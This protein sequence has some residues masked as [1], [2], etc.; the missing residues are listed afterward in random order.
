MGAKKK[1]YGMFLVKNG[2][3][4]KKLASLE[5][6]VL[7]TQIIQCFSIVIHAEGQYSWLKIR[8]NRANFSLS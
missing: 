4:R 1:K 7:N 2:Y 5:A 3:F 8:G 6:L